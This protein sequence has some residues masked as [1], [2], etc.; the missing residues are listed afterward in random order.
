MMSPLQKWMSPKM[1]H[2]VH[3]VLVVLLVLAAGACRR[4]A[5]PPPSPA[6]PTTAPAA[7]ASGMIAPAA[8]EDVVERDP[9]YLVGISYPPVARQYPGLA[10]LLKAYADA[11]R[12]E[13]MQ[14][15]A[16]LGS[17]KPIAPYDLSLGFDQV[18]AT[19]EIVAVAAQGSSY[20]GG[21]HGNPLVARFVWL[22]REGRQLTVAALV[23]DPHAWQAISDYVREQLQAALAERVDADAP[24]PAERA[25]RI[26]NG[27]RMIDEGTAPVPANFDQFEPVLDA[28]GRIQALRFVF[29]PYQVGP[30]SD[31][32]QAVEVPAA[33]LL[34]MVA[35]QYR[36]LF[37]G[38]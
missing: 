7:A 11:A 2:V 9:R 32:V 28:G 30:Y 19:P 25:D 8:L 12:G 33:V 21:A 1:I 3:V 22:P 36:P 29:P 35:I 18:V 17:D 27:S 26:G 13:L 4:E 37:Q 24:T 20:T 14:A 6:V 31:G 34:P 23:P 5:T 38:G 15:V 10:A 16:G